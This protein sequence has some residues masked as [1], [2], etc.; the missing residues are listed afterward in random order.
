RADSNKPNMGLTSWKNEKIGGKIL[1]SDVSI[2]KNYLIEEEL[3]EMNRVV[4][5]YLDFAENMAKR[6]KPL[7]MNDW[8]KKLNDFLNLNEYEILSNAGKVSHDTAKKL[9]ESEYEKY[10]PIQD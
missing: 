10:R 3:R 1:K 2:A 4:S 6:M 9:A 5:Q 8:I 7:T